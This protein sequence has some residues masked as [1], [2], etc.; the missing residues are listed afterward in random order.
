M[1]CADGGGSYVDALGCLV[2]VYKITSLH[3]VAMQELFLCSS[4][5]E[6]FR[7]SRHIPDSRSYRAVADFSFFSGV[8]ELQRSITLLS[9]VTG[10]ITPASRLLRFLVVRLTRSRSY[11]L[12]LFNRSTCL[13]VTQV[14]CL[15]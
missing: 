1:Y 2:N 9:G 5:S 4:V 14:L 15:I 10:I 6:L 8:A 11:G 7:L 3:F 13:F 12:V